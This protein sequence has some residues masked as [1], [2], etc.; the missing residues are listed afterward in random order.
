MD[1]EGL[2]EQALQQK[3]SITR[4]KAGYDLDQVDELLDEVVLALREGAEPGQIVQSLTAA[5]L[6]QTR[7]RDGYRIDEVDGFLDRLVRSLSQG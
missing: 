1:R 4:F 7:W 5:R 6:R 2:A 3:F